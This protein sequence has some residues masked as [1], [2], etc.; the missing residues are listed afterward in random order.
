MHSHLAEIK[1]V[2][3]FFRKEISLLYKSKD[4]LQT[5]VDSNFIDF[6]SN[7]KIPKIVIE[8]GCGNGRHPI[9][10]AKSNP[11]SKIV[12][13]ERTKNKFQ[14]FS[15]RLKNHSLFNIHPVNEDALYWLP[16]NIKESSVEE[17]FFL[18][19][20]PYPKE[21]QANKR[22]HRN[23]LFHFILSSIKPQGL[24]HFASNDLSYINECELY[25]MHF[26]KLNLVKKQKIND[27]QIT[28]YRTQFEKKY[29][30]SNQDCYNLI[31]QKP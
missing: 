12:A 20:N 27:S 15:S 28:K 24:I 19:P 7:Q 29:L 1:P 16:S 10:W 30:Q 18:Y 14:A 13:I 5:L 11:S 4:S 25:C 26:W 31:F 2:R 9:E 22:W 8:V 23:P 3:S 6:I 17:Y 21:K